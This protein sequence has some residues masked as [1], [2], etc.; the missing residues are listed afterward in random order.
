MPTLEARG[1]YPTTLGS[2]LEDLYSDGRDFADLVDMIQEK[3]ASRTKAKSRGQKKLVT[4][5]AP[6]LSP[7]FKKSISSFPKSSVRHFARKSAGIS[8]RRG[9]AAGKIIDLPE[10]AQRLAIKKN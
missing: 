1:K 2:L 6:R 3:K 10:L 4:P 8:K 9:H 5:A 7:T